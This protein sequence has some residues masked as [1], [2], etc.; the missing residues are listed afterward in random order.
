MRR[1]AT[2]LVVLIGCF[3]VAAGVLIAHARPAGAQ[4]TARKATSA[5]AP[6]ATSEPVYPAGFDAPMLT[7]LVDKHLADA[8]AA[9]ERLV[10]A[11]A[12][13]DMTITV[14]RGTI[15]YDHR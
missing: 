3:G 7:R 10:G 12:E 5:V 11:A 1:R 4:Q 13:L 15:G 9:V 14:R 6:P 2:S 8:R